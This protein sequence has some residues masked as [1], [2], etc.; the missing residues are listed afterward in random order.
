MWASRL[1]ECASGGEVLINNQLYQILKRRDTGAYTERT[2]TPKDGPMSAWALRINR[3]NLVRGRFCRP[4]G[5]TRRL[6]NIHGTI[7]TLRER[8]SPGGNLR[9]HIEKYDQREAVAVLKRMRAKG[10][11]SFVR[12][13]N[14]SGQYEAVPEPSDMESDAIILTAEGIEA[15][16]AHLRKWGVDF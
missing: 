1:A 8:Y 15:G 4:S 3:Q 14:Q 11:L 7:T 16:K 12:D 9:R 6:L 13:V 10:W 5:A 2:V